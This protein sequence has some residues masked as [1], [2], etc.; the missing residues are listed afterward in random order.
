M[1]VVYHGRFVCARILPKLLHE[2][3]KT[4]PNDSSLRVVVTRLRIYL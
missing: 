1:H 3:K 4:T 2:H